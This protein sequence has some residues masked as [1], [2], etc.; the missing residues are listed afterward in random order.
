MYIYN[1]LIGSR[2]QR[3][4]KLDS[5]QNND[6]VQTF[7]INMEPVAKGRP[8]FI[9]ST[10]RTYTPAKTKEAT[11]LISEH[12]VLRKLGKILKK[13]KTGEKKY[14]VAIYMRFLCSRP[15]RLGKG[16]RILK[17]TKPDVDNYI[18]LILDAC[19]EAEIWED[20]SMVVEVLGQKWYCADYEKPQVQIQINRV[21]I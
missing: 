8:R 9:K 1:V 10:G 21:L 12:L 7:C 16:D 11:K 13:D 6:N 3:M 15:K 17:T 14:G 5:E 20:D 19:N 4:K 2:K 18:K